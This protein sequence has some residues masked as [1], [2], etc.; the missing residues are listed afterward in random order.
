MSFFTEI[1]AT[2]KIMKKKKKSGGYILS[3]IKAHTKLQWWRN[4][5]QHKIQQVIN[6]SEVDLILNYLLIE[7]KEREKIVCLINAAVSFG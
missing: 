3:A 4:E 5:V 6:E 7:N 2:N 1:E